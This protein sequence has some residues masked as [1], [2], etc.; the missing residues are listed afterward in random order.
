MR[1]PIIQHRERRIGAGVGTTLAGR[2]YI[3]NFASTNACGQF[4]H[5]GNSDSDG[6]S[7]SEAAIGDGDRYSIGTFGF[8][9]ECG[10]G[11]QLPGAAINTK[12]CRIGAT[13]SVCQGVII[14][15][16]CCDCGTDVYV[17]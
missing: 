3:S 8:I 9:V 11:L 1:L 5:V 16:R 2:E 10:L 13:E 15:V 17:G 14:R 6:D 4:V 7:V 12:R